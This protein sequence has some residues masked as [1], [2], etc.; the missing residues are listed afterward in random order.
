M[1]FMHTSCDDMHDHVV[2]IYTL[3]VVRYTLRVMTYSLRLITY[4]TLLRLH[5]IAYAMDKNLL[6]ILVTSTTMS[7]YIII[8]KENVYHQNE[9]LYI[10]IA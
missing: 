1:F 7:L 10:I 5:T 4:A 9:V 6:K 8:F 2:I 3:W